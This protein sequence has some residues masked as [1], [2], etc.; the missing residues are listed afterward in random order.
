MPGQAVTSDSTV[1]LAGGP[2]C[3]SGTRDD[4]LCPVPSHKKGTAAPQLHAAAEGLERRAGEPGRPGETGP[5]ASCPTAA[6]EPGMGN[7]SPAG[8]G[9]QLEGPGPSAHPEPVTAEG[10]PEAALQGV[11]PAAPESPV[12]PRQGDR[13]EA[14]TGPST[15]ESTL[16][17]GALRAEQPAPGLEP[18]ACSENPSPAA[19]GEDQVLQPCHSPG[20]PSAWLKM[21][22]VC[23]P[24]VAL[25]GSLL[26]E[27]GAAG[28]LGVPGAG[29]ATEQKRSPL[30]P[31]V[32][33]EDSEA[34]S[35]EL[36]LVQGVGTKTSPS[37]ENTD[38][39]GV[40]R[41]EAV[42]TAAA[43]P[44]GPSRPGSKDFSH[45]S[46][47]IPLP[48]VVLGMENSVTLGL[49]EPALGGVLMDVPA[50]AAPEMPPA[51]CQEDQ[52]EGADHSCAGCGA[53]DT[54][55]DG[56]S[57]WPVLQARLP[58]DEAPAGGLPCRAAL[59]TGGDKSACP[60]PPGLSAH[61]QP[62]PQGAHSIEAAAN[63][64]VEAVM[65]WVRASGALMPQ[66]AH[67]HPE[68]VSA[69]EGGARPPEVALE[70]S[71]ERSLPVRGPA[72]AAGEWG[73]HG[74][75]PHAY[76][77]PCPRGAEVSGQSSF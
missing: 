48:E 73:W 49:P 56:K 42:G 4:A 51:D 66:G 13:A 33:P 44:Q 22:T 15:E 28:G 71:E 61:R 75:W 21:E 2:G 17:S 67:A 6:L 26:S 65:E 34:P 55:M 59:P 74:K 52:L 5:S 24:E 50:A 35:C 41:D 64:I 1:S 31:Q 18:W 54:A 38:P 32:R 47:D 10:G 39:H 25:Q 63:H 16:P 11:G 19:H 45:D 14:A 72:A 62:L 69:E 36:P 46:L 68:S 53:T 77:C 43:G 76:L 30:S 37:Q 40:R 27:G 8:L 3:E 70:E 20:T 57:Q 29:P 23:D 7:T 12:A 9:G 58:E 60:L